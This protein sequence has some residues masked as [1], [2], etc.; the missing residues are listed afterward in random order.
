MAVLFIV[1]PLDPA[2]EC[3]SIQRHNISIFLIVKLWFAKVSI[4]GLIIK[5]LIYQL[6]KKKLFW[7]MRKIHT[8]NI[9]LPFCHVEAFSSSLYATGLGTYSLMEEVCWTMVIF[10]HIIWFMVESWIFAIIPHLFV[11]FYIW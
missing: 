6:N 11:L 9:C 8:Y 5:H 2:P 7:E 4:L 3:K 10:I 1:L